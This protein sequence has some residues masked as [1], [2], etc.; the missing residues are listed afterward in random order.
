MSLLNYLKVF[1]E[2][3]STQGTFF[4]KVA[5]SE[6]K[7]GLLLLK[8]PEPGFLE[9]VKSIRYSSIFNSNQL[10]DLFCIN[11]FSN[12]KNSIFH[13]F[14]SKV[15]KS[16]FLLVSSCGR[17]AFSIEN[18]HFNADWAE[19][20]ASEMSGIPFYSKNDSRN[21]LM[22]YGYFMYPLMKSNPSIGFFEVFYDLKNNALKNH[23]NSF[24]S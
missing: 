11:Q 5:N 1:L 10:I 9:A 3:I 20:E 7:N 21:L 6:P 13:L 8:L 23:L 14:Y 22:V 15:A 2:S 12:K 4:F 18:L 19:R 16:L 24:S 17:G